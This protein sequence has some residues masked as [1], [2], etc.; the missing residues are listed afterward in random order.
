M[1]KQSW[2]VACNLLIARFLQHN[3]QQPTSVY[4]LGPTSNALQL[5]VAAIF[6]VA[7]PLIFYIVSLSL[8][9]Y[10]NFLSPVAAFARFLH[11][12]TMVWHFS[13][14]KIN[15]RHQHHFALPHASYSVTSS[16]LVF[17]V[18]VLASDNH[19]IVVCR[20]HINFDV[21]WLFYR[22]C[23]CCCCCDCQT[24]L[25]TMTAA[26]ALFKSSFSSSSLALLHV[27]L[28]LSKA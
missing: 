28:T 7:L 10:L 16:T 13:I 15:R 4:L 3:L 26:T 11:V 5:I 12:I 2:W 25:M 21:A 9:Y 17:A 22:R 19:D 20:C 8:L 14:I 23:C 1:Q 18:V 6:V 24:L 27:Q